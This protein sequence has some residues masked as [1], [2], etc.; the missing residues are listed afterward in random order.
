MNRRHDDFD[1]Q[2]PSFYEQ[3]LRDLLAIAIGLTFGFALCSGWM[4]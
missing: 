3:L 4:V 2:K 1:D